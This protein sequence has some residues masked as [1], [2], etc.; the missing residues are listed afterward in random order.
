MDQEFAVHFQS[1]QKLGKLLQLFAILSIL[2]A[3][4]GLFGLASFLALEKAKE[5]SIRK[6]IGASEEQLVLLLSWSFLKLIL[7][8]NVLAIPISYQLMTHWLEQFAYKTQ[9]PIYVFLLASGTTISITI[10]TIGFHVYKTAT[11]N[12]VQ[13]LARE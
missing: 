4:L 12:P 11:M 8:A 13:V 5:M 7:L 10:L 6:V 2:V 3:I 1:D 9:I